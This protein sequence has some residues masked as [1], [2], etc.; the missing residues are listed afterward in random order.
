MSGSG[1][2]PNENA[3]IEAPK[4]PAQKHIDETKERLATLVTTSLHSAEIAQV[5]VDDSDILDLSAFVE[6]LETQLMQLCR[7]DMPA[8]AIML[9]AVGLTPESDHFDQLWAEV[10]EIVQSN[11]RGIDLICRLRQNTVCVFLP[12]STLNATLE[13]AGGMQHMLKECQ[14]NSAIKHYPER[15]AIAI[16]SAQ[17][18]EA[19]GVFLQRLEDALDEA[20]DAAPLELVV[21]EATSSYF[22]AT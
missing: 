3:P 11:L 16:A 17:R 6:R 19:A 10:L 18:N 2:K 21:S 1:P 22:H 12:G 13:R 15:F 8:T 5:V 20:Q 4:I 14:A 9:E 7:A